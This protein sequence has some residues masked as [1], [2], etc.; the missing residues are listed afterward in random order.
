M[1]RTLAGR[2]VACVVHGLALATWFIIFQP[3]SA[4]PLSDALPPQLQPEATPADSDTDSSSSDID[5]T[6]YAAEMSR[7]RHRHLRRHHVRHHKDRGETEKAAEN[8]PAATPASAARPTQAAPGA[9]PMDTDTDTDTETDDVLTPKNLFTNA[10]SSEAS[11]A[12]SAPALQVVLT[13]ASGGD[14]F[15]QLMTTY[16]WN[17]L[18]HTISSDL[19]FEP[20]RRTAELVRDQDDA[21]GFRMATTYGDA[22]LYEVLLQVA[23]PRGY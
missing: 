17:H 14:P 19:V 15:E 18:D 8:N 4:S 5:I 13:T 22:T 9:T 10:S 12:R 21:F 2:L 11:S 3:A 16:Y 23:R 20:R 6:A 7:F 1:H